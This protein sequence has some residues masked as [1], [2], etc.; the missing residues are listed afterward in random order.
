MRRRPPKSTPTDTR[1]PYT[2]LFRSAALGPADPLVDHFE[3]IAQPAERLLG[4]TD[5]SVLHRDLAIAALLRSVGV[6]PDSAVPRGELDGVGQQVENDL[7]DRPLIRM[8]RL[9][10][11]A[12][13]RFQCQSDLPGP[14]LDQ[15]Q[16]IVDLGVQVDML[17]LQLVAARLD[18][19]HVE[20]VV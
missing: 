5:P 7:A 14:A 3:G 10:V 11:I 8:D 20:H 4:N 6:D 19:R 16:A 13:A 12:P 17:P 1:F 2:T 9:D 18:L 15:P